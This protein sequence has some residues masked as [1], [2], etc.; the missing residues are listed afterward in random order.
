MSRSFAIAV[1]LGGAFAALEADAKAIEEASRPAAQ[2]GAQVLYEAVK[3]NVAALRRGTGKLS[4]SIYQKHSPEQSVGGRQVYNIS[5]NYRKAPHGHLIE[6]GW[7]QRY[8]VYQ[9]NDGQIRP[10]V[11]PGMEGLPRPKRGA[12]R[13]QKDAYY[14]PLP[15][16][17]RQV[18]GK[19]FVRSAQSQFPKAQAAMEAEF[20]NQLRK[21]GVIR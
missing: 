12:S 7:I 13:A 4:Q 14:V 2:A 21:R 18:A 6:W 5:W 20:L 16:G 15:G 9:G 11:R 19:A 17:P 10:L 3:T 8:V 1:D